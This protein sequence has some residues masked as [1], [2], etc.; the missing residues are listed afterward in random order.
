M[1][2]AGDRAELAAGVWIVVNAAAEFACF[3]RRGGVGDRAGI[4]GAQHH[5]QVLWFPEKLRVF[6]KRQLKSKAV[7]FFRGSARLGRP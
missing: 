5:Q 2:A 7:R 4:G 1:V 6:T 3:Q